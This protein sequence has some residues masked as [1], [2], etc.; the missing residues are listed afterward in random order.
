M[1]TVID[2][3]EVQGKGKAVI[4]LVGEHFEIDYY[5]D[6]GRHY[7]NEEYVNKSIHYVTDAAENWTLGIKKLEDDTYEQNQDRLQVRRG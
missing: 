1:S 7:F 4:S 3:Y 2:T 6:Y 5:D